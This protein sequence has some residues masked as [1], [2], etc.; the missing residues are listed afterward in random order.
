[1]GPF[2][3]ITLYDGKLKLTIKLAKNKHALQAFGA[4]GVC[5]PTTEERI[6][7]TDFFFFATLSSRGRLFFIRKGGSSSFFNASRLPFY[8]KTFYALFSTPPLF[9][10]GFKIQEKATTLRSDP[11]KRGRQYQ[12]G[13][14]P[15]CP[16]PKLVTWPKCFK[17]E[18]TEFKLL[19][20]MSLFFLR[21]LLPFWKAQNQS[22][23]D[24][25]GRNAGLPPLHFLASRFTLFWVGIPQ[26]MRNR[27]EKHIKV[28]GPN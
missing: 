5:F 21:R 25:R 23:L 14:L 22:K 4:A 17:D 12:E 10:G 24:G 19:C 3:G 1:M 16:I 20:G 18:G 13:P 11:C 7:K 26:L 2:C 9:F 8:G 6:R 15:G 27:K 28:L